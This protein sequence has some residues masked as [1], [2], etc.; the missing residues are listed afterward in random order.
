M[1]AEAGVPSSARHTQQDLR[2]RGQHADP[3]KLI[4]HPTIGG[5][6]IRTPETITRLT[7]FKTV[8]FSRSATPPDEFDRNRNRPA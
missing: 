2:K 1:R 3:C 7:V 5:G 8:A 6:G 4:R